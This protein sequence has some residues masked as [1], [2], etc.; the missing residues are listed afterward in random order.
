MA[1]DNPITRRVVIS[2]TAAA[3]ATLHALPAFAATGG[4]DA[5]LGRVLI[6]SRLVTAT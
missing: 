6:K 1:T 3:A 2:G 5:K 4:D